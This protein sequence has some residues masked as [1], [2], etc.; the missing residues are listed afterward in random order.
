VTRLV[1]C[2]H[3]EP[4]ESAR[5]RLCGSFDPVL[6]TTGRAQAEALAT[7]LAGAGAVYTSPA[8]RALDT[9]TRLGPEPVVEAGLRELDFG[10]A[11]GLRY[12]EVAER[13]PQ[14]YDE[15]LRAP[16]RVSFPGGESFADF[17]ARVLAALA[18]VVRRESAAVVV[19]HAGVIRTALAHW[20]SIP[21]EG[22]FRIDQGYGCVTVVDWFDETPL[23]RLVNGSPASLAPGD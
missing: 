23:V 13:W 11:D 14:L 6:S 4:E 2:R 3:G 21:D 20:L 18:G 8:R 5:G 9:A 7:A 15:W 1:L 17:R 12:E 16:T 22:L 19:T 10:E